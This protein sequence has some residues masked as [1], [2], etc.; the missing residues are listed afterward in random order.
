MKQDK[1][2]AARKTYVGN[3][4]GGKDLFWVL[5]IGFFVVLILK[6]LGKL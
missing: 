5:Y 1:K 4:E 2:L 3:P 6:G